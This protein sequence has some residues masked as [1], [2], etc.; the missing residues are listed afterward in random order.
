MDFNAPWEYLVN[1]TGLAGIVNAIV[2]RTEPVFTGLRHGKLSY[3]FN[4]VIVGHLVLSL[5]L[6]CDIQCGK[7]YILTIKCSK[8]W[9]EFLYPSTMPVKI[10]VQLKCDLEF[11]FLFDLWCDLDLSLCS[12]ECHQRGQPHSA[13]TSYRLHPQRSDIFSC[14]NHNIMYTSNELQSF[15][16]QSTHDKHLIARSS[17]NQSHLTPKYAALFVNIIKHVF[18]FCIIS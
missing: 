16:S 13:R 5:L 1:S 17:Q 4:T 12:P 14:W 3:F 10:M 9:L 7:L 11:F 8:F 18:T 15:S 6:T 2:Y